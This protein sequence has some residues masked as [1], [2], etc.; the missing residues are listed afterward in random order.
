MKALS[1]QSKGQLELRQAEPPQVGKDEVLIRTGACVIC[2][3]DIK[4][5]YENP[6]GIHFPVIPGHEPA[7]TVVSAGENV[8]QFRQGDRVAAHPVHPCGLCARCREG[9]GH[10]CQDMRHLGLNMQGAFAE[11][12]VAREDR[13]RLIPSSCDFVLAALLEPVCVCL[14][15]LNQ[16]RLSKGRK[17]LI[18]GDGPFGLIMSRLAAE[19]ELKTVV[20]AGH[21]DFRLR[22]A[23]TARTL[24]TRQLKEPVRELLKM[25]GDGGYDAVIMTVGSASAA[26]QGLELLKPKGRLVLFAP[27]AGDTPLD[28]T[29]AV[30]NELEIVGANNDQ[31]LIDPALRL[32]TSP[33]MKLHEL[34][35]HR[36]PIEQFEE[37]FA[38]AKSGKDSAIK[39]AIVFDQEDTIPGKGMK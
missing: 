38:L 10:L 17:L 39:V 23:N 31:N 30:F 22:L 18:L 12:F 37:A 26:K 34:V 36:F 28:L 6:F 32:L 1:I 19:F 9:L 33:E 16:A 7:G 15:G 25:S 24:N 13:I 11:Y 20:V 14:E 2:T 21:H 3:S 27:I 35:T 29:R 4:D 8:T 5:I